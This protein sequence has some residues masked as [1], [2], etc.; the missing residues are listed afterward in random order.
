M[1]GSSVSSPP[2]LRPGALDFCLKFSPILS[3]DLTQ[4]LDKGMLS[5]AP[6]SLTHFT[7]KLSLES[8]EP[9]GYQESSSPQDSGNGLSVLSWILYLQALCQDKPASADY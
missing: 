8:P 9:L 7:M 2:L 5:G 1:L 3:L 4:T 6:D